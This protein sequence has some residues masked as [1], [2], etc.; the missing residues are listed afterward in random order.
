MGGMGC[1]CSTQQLF[2]AGGDGITG[3]PYLESAGKITRYKNKDTILLHGKQFITCPV[4]Q[5]LMDHMIKKI[6]TKIS[7]CSVQVRPQ[8]CDF[9]AEMNGCSD[10]AFDENIFP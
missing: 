7:F 10:L 6:K 5:S 9:D 4:L 2:G 3:L 8:N 1:S